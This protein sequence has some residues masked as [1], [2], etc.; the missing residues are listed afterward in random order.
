MITGVIEQFDERRGYGYLRSD[1]GHR[2]FFHCV[3]IAD[4]ARTISVQVRARGDRSVGHLGHDEIVNVKAV[5][6]S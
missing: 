2:F 5:P 3:N 4:G 1:D 6:A